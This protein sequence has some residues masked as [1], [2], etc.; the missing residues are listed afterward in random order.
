MGKTADMKIEQ[1][2]NGLA[3]RIPSELARSAHFTLGQPIELS[4]QESGVLM[5]STGAPKLSLAQKLA[6]FDPEKHGGEVMA[7]EPVGVEIF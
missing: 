4:L 2:G 3:I 6:L 5:T 7:T 1:W